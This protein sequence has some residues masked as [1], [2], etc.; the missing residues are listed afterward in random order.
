MK[1]NR[2][3]TL[4]ALVVYVIVMV[5]VLGVIGAILNEFYSN[6]EI[7]EADTEDIVELNRFNSYFLKEIKTRNNKVDT[8]ESNYILFKSGNSFSFSNHAIYY[9]NIVICRGVQGVMMQLGKNEDGINN[10]IIN[11]VIT[12]NNYS[13]ILNYKLENIF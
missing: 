7:L 2:G 11:V 8:I 5:I 12:F 3:I 4:A 1:S 13:K 10:D 9:N 6:N